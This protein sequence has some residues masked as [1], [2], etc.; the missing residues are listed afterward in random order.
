M[1]KIL[2][3]GCGID[4]YGTHFVDLFPQRKNVMKCDLDRQKLPFSD[5]Y[6]DEVYSKNLFEHLTNL[7]FAIK[8]MYR[9]LKKGGKLILITD[10]AN[11]FGFAIG[12]THLGGYEEKKLWSKDSAKEDRHYELFTDWHLRNYAKKAGFK[13][14]LTE[15]IL[16]EGENQN[17]LIGIKGKMIKFF[18]L[19]LRNTPFKRTAYNLVKLEAMK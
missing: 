18:S 9:V 16:E 2:N 3:V 1:K 10:N 5:N 11:F 7:G 8:E 19:L 6:F 17:N 12:G 13:T 15:Y 14:A 4:D